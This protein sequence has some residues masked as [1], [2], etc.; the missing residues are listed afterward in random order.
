MP[1]FGTENELV[2]CQG[3]AGSHETFCFNLA[4]GGNGATSDV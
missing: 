4:T 2:M 3:I 1:G